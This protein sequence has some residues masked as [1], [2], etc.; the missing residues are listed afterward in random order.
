MY[1]ESL[2]N[3]SES[4]PTAPAGPAEIARMSS[5]EKMVDAALRSGKHLP[6]G[7]RDQIL[8]AMNWQSLLIMLGVLLLVGFT[9]YAVALVIGILFTGMSMRNLVNNVTAELGEF[10]RLACTA[11][12][13]EQLDLAGQHFARAI[14]LIGVELF[15]MLIS[16]MAG[17]GVRFLGARLLTI[18]GPLRRTQ[19]KSGDV[20]SSGGNQ[21][22]PIRVDANGQPLG[23]QLLQPAAEIGGSGAGVWDKIATIQR[24]INDRI[25]HSGNDL[26]AKTNPTDFTR[27]NEARVDPRMRTAQVVNLS[28]YWKMSQGTCRENAMLTQVALQAAGFKVRY[29]E[30]TAILGS[31]LN[32]FKRFNHAWNEVNI[33]GRWYMVD[34][35]NPHLNG[36][37]VG[38]ARFWGTVDSGAR[39]IPKPGF[40]RFEHHAPPPAPD[41][42]VH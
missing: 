5:M 17:Y 22:P 2:N 34:T 26:S 7:V 19:L 8:G 9:G 38:D 24:L 36:L 40:P 23:P 15:L 32:P 13:P 29:V 20:L 35:T 16:G 6:P 4:A 25:S 18:I 12:T 41:P 3:F 33:G 27:F 42:F 39:L 31:A 10:R 30:G 11:N 14:S 28:E 21:T 1:P 37:P